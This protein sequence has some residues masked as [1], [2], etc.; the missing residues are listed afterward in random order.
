M[1]GYVVFIILPVPYFP[2]LSLKKDC[3]QGLLYYIVQKYQLWLIL[4]A[5]ISSLWGTK[6]SVLSY[7]FASW[8]TGS[9]ILCLHK[10]IFSDVY[11]LHAFSDWTAVS[12]AWDKSKLSD[13]CLYGYWKLKF[14]TLWIILASSSLQSEKKIRTK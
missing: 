9:A 7:T 8:Q 6:C 11:R 5:I 3:S 4:C 1:S 12:R 14:Q 10:D 2:F 13:T